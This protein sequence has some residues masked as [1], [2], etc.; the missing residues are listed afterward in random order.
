M[1]AVLYSENGTRWKKTKKKTVFIKSGAANINMTFDISALKRRRWAASYA[2][3]SNPLSDNSSSQNTA[4]FSATCSIQPGSLTS[5]IVPNEKQWIRQACKF[6]FIYL[7][8]VIEHLLLMIKQTQSWYAVQTKSGQYIIFYHVR[9]WLMLFS[10]SSFSFL[11]VLVFPLIAPCDHIT[12]RSKNKYISY[13]MQQSSKHDPPP[14]VSDRRH[15][16][17]WNKDFGWK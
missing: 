5:T 17:S 16:C 7:F 11:I 2:L 13:I 4:G 10:F 6:C 15:V 8:S 9:F 3:L 1:K 12:R 14:A